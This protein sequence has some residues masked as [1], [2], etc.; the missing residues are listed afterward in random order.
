MTSHRLIVPAPV[1]RSVTVRSPQARAF[2]VFA[3]RIGAW[4]PPTHHIGATPFRDIVLEP[5][6][7][8]RWYEV[9]GDGSECDWGH[10][11]AWE[12][13]S[14]L[15]LAWQIDAQ[16][17]FDAYNVFNHPVLYFN[18]NQGNTCVDC[19]VTA[20]QITDIEQDGSPGSPTGMR[21]LQFGVRFTF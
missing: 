21:Q 17:R 11:L 9:G 16:F 3:A 15:L 20:G 14:R 2:E 18:S 6:V 1:R 19:G 12:P 7:G 5:R 4:W 10:V 8:G 13:P